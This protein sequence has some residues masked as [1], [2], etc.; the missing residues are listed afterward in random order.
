LSHAPLSFLALRA[1][2]T[3][4]LRAKLGKFEK[5]AQVRGFSPPQGEETPQLTQRIGARPAMQ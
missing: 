5:S 2:T 4:S 1:L 3:C